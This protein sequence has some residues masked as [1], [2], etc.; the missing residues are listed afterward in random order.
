MSAPTSELDS[1][2]DEYLAGTQ[3]FMIS[4]SRFMKLYTG[5]DLSEVEAITYEPAY[6]IV[7]MGCEGEPTTEEGAAGVL[8]ESKL[9]AQLR[10][11]RTQLQRPSSA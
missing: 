8:G 5:N 3:P 9:R 6:D 10:Q 7:Y 4:W 1:L 11:F 2:I